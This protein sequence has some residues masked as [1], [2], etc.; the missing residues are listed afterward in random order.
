MTIAVRAETAPSA[1]RRLALACLIFF[2]C[3]VCCASLV[4]ISYFKFP[5]YFTAATFHIFYDPPRFYLAAAVCVLFGIVSIVFV[6][7]RFSFG[8]FIGFY[9]YSMVLSYLLLNC[10]S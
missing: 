2:H 8:Y 3:L 1:E 6:Y 5:D 10:F 7:A 4:Y 9:L